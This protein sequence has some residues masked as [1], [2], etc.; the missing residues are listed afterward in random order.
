MGFAVQNNIR[1]DL[2]H[3]FSFCISGQCSVMLNLT[4]NEMQGEQIS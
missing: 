1:N 3:Y 4:P 2:F